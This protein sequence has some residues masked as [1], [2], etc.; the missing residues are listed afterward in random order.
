MINRLELSIDIKA[1][2][3]TIWQALWNEHSYREW[4]GVFFQ[5]SYLVTDNWEEGSK[6]QFLAPDQSGIYSKIEK[7][8]PNKLIRF[9]HIGKVLEGKEQAEDEETK[10]WTGCTETYTLKEG[11][12]HITLEVEIDVMEEHL[13]FM[14]QTFPK[15]LEKVK[16]NCS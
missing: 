8:L 7:H 3:S 14:T 1:E 15:A 5:G 6:V 13:E 10:K 4:A 16:Q 2:K 12:E 9:K 11:K